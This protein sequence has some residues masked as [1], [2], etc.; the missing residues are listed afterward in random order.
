MVMVAGL[1]PGGRFQAALEPD[2]NGSHWFLL[3]RQ[4]AGGH[5]EFELELEPL[6]QW[7]EP[8]VPSDL[9]QALAS[10]PEARSRWTDITA[11]ARWDWIRWIGTAKQRPTR[12]RR[13]EATCSMLKQGKRRPCCFNREQRSLTDA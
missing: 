11:A 10:D 3:D 7:P 2:G 1:A 9:D 13:I 6:K 8:K 4:L 12:E 5:K